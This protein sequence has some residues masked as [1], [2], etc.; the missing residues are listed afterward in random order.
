MGKLCICCIFFH[1]VHFFPYS[2]SCVWLWYVWPWTRSHG[3]KT[4]WPCESAPGRNCTV[5]GCKCCS[6]TS[7]QY[8]LQ[9]QITSELQ[10]GEGV[11][12]QVNK[13]VNN[14]Q[15]TIYQKQPTVLH[16]THYFGIFCSYVGVFVGRSSPCYYFDDHSW[17]IVL[18]LQH[19]YCYPPETSSDGPQLEGHCSLLLSTCNCGKTRHLDFLTKWTVCI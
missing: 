14:E 8:P 12:F 7:I 16:H 5:V 3:G 10:E 1:T 15:Q 2:T 17:H 11:V 9:K 4:F 6:S 13:E 18:S 19:L